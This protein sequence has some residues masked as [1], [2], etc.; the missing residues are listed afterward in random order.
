MG[1]AVEVSA[2]IRIDHLGMSGV[3]EGMDPT[4][5]VQRTTLGAVPN[6]TL[7]AKTTIPSRRTL[8]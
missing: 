1:Q 8:T 2:Q 4:H 6:G 5:R 7:E 3:Q